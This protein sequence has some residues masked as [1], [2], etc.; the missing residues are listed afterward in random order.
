[1]NI[2]VT[3]TDGV[4]VVRFEGDLD[5]NSAPEAQEK[6]DALV[7]QGS[8]K[9]LLDFKGLGYISSAGLRVLFVTHR[10][11]QRSSGKLHICSSNEMVTEVFEITGFSTIFSVFSTESE[12]M[13]GF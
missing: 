4:T 13:E 7:C 6:L 10:N 3:E 9:V 2:A 1:M 12:A 8:T 11:L 5:I